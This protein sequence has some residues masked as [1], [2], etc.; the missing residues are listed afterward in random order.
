MIA[1]ESPGHT[2]RTPSTDSGTEVRFPTASAYGT[3]DHIIIDFYT[4]V[5]SGLFIIGSII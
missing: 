3:E 5:V 2:F 1:M 4:Y